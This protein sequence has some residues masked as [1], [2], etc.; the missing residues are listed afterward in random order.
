VEEDK[1]NSSPYELVETPEFLGLVEDVIG[2]MD[3]WDEIKRGRDWLLERDPKRGSYLPHY[4]LWVL[5][6]RTHPAIVVY[7]EIDEA[8]R[9]V[10]P[11]DIHILEV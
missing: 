8:Q 4:D 7:Y 10:I 11:T 6:F 1:P 9:Q 2:S 5:F 3:R